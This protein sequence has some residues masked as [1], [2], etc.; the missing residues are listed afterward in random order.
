MCVFDSRKSPMKQRNKIIY[1]IPCLVKHA[2]FLVIIVHWRCT[3][4]IFLLSFLHSDCFHSSPFGA[5]VVYYTYFL[6]VVVHRYLLQ[7]SLVQHLIVHARKGR[8]WNAWS[9]KML[10][11][12]ILY[13]FTDFLQR[14][15]MP[16]TASTFSV[17]YS[18]TP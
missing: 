6:Y 10:Y 4:T 12:L 2:I 16:M 18:P 17:H 3:E 15:H 5:D 14:F 1:C 7:I 13:I 8:S 11:V 9:N